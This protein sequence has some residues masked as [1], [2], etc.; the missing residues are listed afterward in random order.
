MRFQ[1]VKCMPLDIQYTDTSTLIRWYGWTFIGEN[2]MII[3]DKWRRATSIRHLWIEA[4]M[5]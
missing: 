1:S 2:T 3:V 5:L 4:V